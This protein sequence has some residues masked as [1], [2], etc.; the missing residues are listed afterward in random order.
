[1]VKN[2]NLILAVSAMTSILDSETKVLSVKLTQIVV[3]KPS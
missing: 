2:D 3:W 1:M